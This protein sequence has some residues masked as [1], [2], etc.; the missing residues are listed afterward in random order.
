VRAPPI[1]RVQPSAAA[2]AAADPQAACP[3]RKAKLHI[4]LMH[5]TAGIC[6][7]N[8]LRSAFIAAVLRPVVSAT[9]MLQVAAMPI[10]CVPHI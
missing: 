1:A 4:D 8:T 10:Q 3:P 9:K 7:T 6:A 5:P 2:L